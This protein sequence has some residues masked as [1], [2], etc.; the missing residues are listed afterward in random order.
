MDKFNKEDLEFYLNDDGIKGLSKEYILN[1]IFDKT[2]QRNWKPGIGDLIVGETGNI[3]TITSS[4]P[5][6]ESI[7]G[8]H[9]YFGGGMCVRDGGNFCNE[10][11]TMVLTKDGIEYGRDGNPVDFSTT[12]RS[13]KNYRYIP[14]PHELTKAK[15]LK[16]YGK[17]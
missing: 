16:Y 6:H 9:F 2:I 11:Y 7:G 4:F 5:F 1:C 13:Y 15:F 8:E 14:Y 10:T 3:Y 12:Y 17:N